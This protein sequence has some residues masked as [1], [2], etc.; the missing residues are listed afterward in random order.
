MSV[1]ATRLRAQGGGIDL[2]HCTVTD[3]A[4]RCADTPAAPRLLVL[5]A[6]LIK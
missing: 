5:A 3:K 1:C 6:Q 2:E 4:S